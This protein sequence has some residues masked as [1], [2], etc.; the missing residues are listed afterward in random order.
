MLLRINNYYMR[1][2][3]IALVSLGVNIVLAAAWLVSLGRRSAHLAGNPASAGQ[4]VGSQIRTNVVV[5]RQF[6]SW[7]QLESPD[8][9]TYVANLRDIG[10]PEQTIRDIIIADVNAMYTRRRATEILTPEQEWWRTEP[11]SNLVQVATEKARALDDERRGLLA[12]L[13]GN[14]WESGDLVNLPRPSRPGVVLDGP[15]LGTLPAETKQAVEEISL[16]VQDRL[17]AYIDQQRSE[18]KNPD[19]VELAKLRQQTRTELQKV[20]NPTQLEEFLLRYSQDANDLRSELGSLRFFNATSNEFREVFRATDNLN[21]QIQ[22]LSGTDPNTVAQR[23]ALEDQ[24]ENA[25]KIVLGA[26][27]YEEYR[28]LHDPV[29]R[30]A[31]ATAQQAGTPEAAQIIYEINLATAEERNRIRGDTNLTAEERN[32]QLKRLELEQLEANTAI[33]H[34]ELALEPPAPPQTPAKKVFVLGPGDSAATIS[35][36][37]GVPLSAIRAANPTLDVSK[38]KPGDT[39]NIPPN[40]FSPAP[41][42]VNLR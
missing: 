32:L 34:P 13:L 10:C 41:L 5:R 3:V 29:Y 18:G 2:R 40:A 1:W 26:N 22:L 23:K 36:L 17:Q 35:A 28:L 37:Y 24:R 11:N 15:V 21:E 12:R 14:N 31:V 19:P 6:F 4:A 20:L 25:I 7:Q 16:Q 38:L 30:D 42:P 33:T 9:Q 27:R 8:Y 39:I